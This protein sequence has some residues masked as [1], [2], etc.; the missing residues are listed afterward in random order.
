M[1][2]A[3]LE[4]I[5]SDAQAFLQQLDLIGRRA[6]FVRVT[7][8]ELARASFLDE[9]LGLQGREGFWLSFRQIDEIASMLP[10]NALLPD[11]IFHIGHCG[12]TLLSRLLDQVPNVLGLRE[13]LPLRD[14]ASI[15]RELDSP[16]SRMDSTHWHSL[17]ATS[18]RLWARPFAPS[19]HTLLK[20]TSTCNNLIAPIL[21]AE[22]GIRAVLLY[23]RLEP[24]LATM[25]KGSGLDA[26]QAAPGRLQFLHEFLDDTAIRLHELEPSEMIAM[27]WIAELARFQQLLARSSSS[28]RLLLLDFEH[29]LAD[30]P[31]MLGGVL[32]HFGLPINAGA[33]NPDAR[34]SILKAYAK[35]PAHAYSAE[36]RNHDLNLSRRSHA[37][38]ISRAMRWAGSVAQRYE[39]LSALRPL[40]G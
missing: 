27:G 30:I 15:G 35:N 1:E 5:S 7:R 24:Y 18:L 23:L 33:G 12:S 40:L 8:D 39:Q 38:G 16:L 37:A 36:D 19:Q 11:F 13:P 17:I 22:P 26:L 6:L 3:A 9:R 32:R 29:L 14:L 20:A 2:R 34:Q 4:S 28:D 31:T 21:Q 25:L 10:A